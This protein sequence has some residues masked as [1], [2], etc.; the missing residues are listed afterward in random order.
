MH[1]GHTDDVCVKITVGSS[2]SGG[3]LGETRRGCGLK[4][5][6]PKVVDYGS[7]A[8]HTFQTPGGQKGCQTNCHI[9][10]FSENS[11]LSGG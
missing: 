2:R 11:A 1:P 3:S 7:I 10:S 6:A 5:E 8:D 9:D 4:Y